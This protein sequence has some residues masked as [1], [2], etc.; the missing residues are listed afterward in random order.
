MADRREASLRAASLI[1]GPEAQEVADLRLAAAGV[2]KWADVAE[3]WRAEQRQR[4][5]E[6]WTVRTFGPEMMTP[7]ERVL[8]VL[9]EALELAQA[10]GLPVLETTRMVDYV[11][12][13]PAGAPAQEV[14]GLRLTI[15][16]YCAAKGLLADDC[17]AAEV[18]R[19]LTKDPQHFRDRNVE[20]AHAGVGDFGIIPAK[21]TP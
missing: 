6:R 13:R 15:L 14:G 5:V 4:I 18:A 3:T 20:K 12:A 8:R 11:Y 2:E 21:E 16:A 17:E 9:E 19:V 7:H 1:D 10:E